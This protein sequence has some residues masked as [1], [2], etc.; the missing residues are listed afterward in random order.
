M[1]LAKVS[2]INPIG[3]GIIKLTNWLVLPLQRVMPHLR[4]FDLPSLSAAYLCSFL[5]FLILGVVLFLIDD[6]AALHVASSLWWLFVM[7]LLN[8]IKLTLYLLSTI[9]LINA[10]LSWI[11]PQS[12]V[13]WIAQQLSAPLLNPLRKYIPAVAG[14]DFTPFALL[15]VFQVLLII[16]HHM[17]Q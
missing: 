5:H 3:Q 6:A 4:L 9:I 14:M 1:Q 7:A 11:N 8:L 17:M 16:V 10:L 12:P 15:I 13:R 2:F